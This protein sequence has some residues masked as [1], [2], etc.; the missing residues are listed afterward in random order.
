MIFLFIWI[1]RGGSGGNRE[2]RFMV[3][4]LFL[5][6]ITTY[7]TSF[8]HFNSLP[9]I[10]DSKEFL[11]VCYILRRN[12][13]PTGVRNKKV[14][15]FVHF[16]KSRKTW[17]MITKEKSYRHTVFAIWHLLWELERLKTVK[18]LII[19]VRSHV[20]VIPLVVKPYNAEKKSIH[21]SIQANSTY[22]IHL[23]LIESMLRR[24]KYQAAGKCRCYSRST[25]NIVPIM[26]ATWIGT[27]F[28]TISHFMLHNNNFNCSAFMLLLNTTQVRAHIL[29]KMVSTR[30]QHGQS[31]PTHFYTGFLFCGCF[32]Q[33]GTKFQTAKT[34]FDFQ[35]CWRR[36]QLF[37]M[38]TT[39]VHKNKW[40]A[41]KKTN[42]RT[43]KTWMPAVS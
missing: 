20:I 22:W 40:I 31:Q 5:Q 7:T 21:L 1:G 29:V 39:I 17:L 9:P 8:Y 15:H 42:R 37:H 28:Y 18:V 2:L 11:L 25:H 33:S 23:T 27:L 6:V 19:V 34:S 13:K 41:K 43:G 26:I 16:T 35:S 24:A 14:T 32:V 12:E 3:S 38:G 30:Q 36:K 4:T 10:I